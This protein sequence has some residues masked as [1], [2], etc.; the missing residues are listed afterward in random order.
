MNIS[1]KEKYD[2]YIERWLA[3]SEDGIRAK[4]TIKFSRDAKRHRLQRVVRPHTRR[5]A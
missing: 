2:R 5:V 4:L 1:H 3:G